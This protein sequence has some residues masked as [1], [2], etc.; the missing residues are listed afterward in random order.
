MLVKP[1][2]MRQ[3]LQVPCKLLCWLACSLCRNNTHRGTRQIGPHQ[4]EVRSFT[5]LDERMLSF[6]GWE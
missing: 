5:D 3:S 2:V 6:S 1:M 4:K